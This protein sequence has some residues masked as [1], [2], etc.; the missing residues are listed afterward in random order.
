MHTSS[1]TLE[2]TLSV[3]LGLCIVA[4]LLLQLSSLYVAP[5]HNSQLWFGDESW[6]MNEYREQMT[7]GVFRHPGAIASTVQ[8]GNPFPFTTMWITSL[9]Y[10]GAAKLFATSNLVDVGR[11]VSAGIAM[12]VIAILLL[13]AKKESLLAVLTGV[14]LLISCRSFFFASHCAR[15]DIMTAMTVLILM[16]YLSARDQL[17]QREFMVV[18]LAIGAGLLVSLHTSVMLAIPVAYAAVLTSWHPIKYTR[19]VLSALCV[20]AVLYLIHLITQPALPSVH[21]VT[22]SVG[23]QPILHL[24]SKSFQRFNLT[25]KGGLLLDYAMPFLAMLAILVAGMVQGPSL[26]RKRL[27]LWVTPIVG[28][29]ILEAGPVSYLIFM[30]PSLA[31]GCVMAIN[32]FDNRIRIGLGIS[33]I[34]LLGFSASD[35]LQAR[36]VG[37]QLAREMST[38]IEFVKPHLREEPAIVMNAAL[39]LLESDP[40]HA[41]IGVFATHFVLLPNIPSRSNPMP[42]SLILFGRHCIPDFNWEAPILRSEIH[43]PDLKLTGQFLDAKRSYFSRLDGSQDTLLLQH[44]DFDTFLQHYRR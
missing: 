7:S 25:H 27:F 23:D 24:F 35:A 15:Y 12:V 36:E 14:A 6:L 21:D 3:V 1:T 43:S 42:G 8:I 2:K 40:K 41:R 28:W 44:I 19:A 38:A 20:V 26:H 9:L 11:T 13:R 18:G 4:V 31:M 33:C 16:R 34:V 22:Y 32:R 29:F 37:G 39:S 30:L 5:I 10:G 17:T